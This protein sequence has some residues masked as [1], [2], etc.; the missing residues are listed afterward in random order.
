MIRLHCRPMQTLDF[1]FRL[2]LQGLG[3]IALVSIGGFGYGHAEDVGT[4]TP[5]ADLSA[6]E[7]V[8]E[9]RLLVAIGRF[10][11]VLTTL[12][13]HRKAGASN[14]DLLFLLGLAA[15]GKAQQ[16]GAPEADRDPLLEEAIAAFRGILADRPGFV[17]ARIELA[18]SYFL[19]ENDLLARKHFE[20]ALAG[21]VPS[22]VAENIRLYLAKI[23]ARKHQGGHR[24]RAPALAHLRRDSPLR[25]LVT[26]LQTC[27]SVTLRL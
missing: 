19:K 27:L 26:Q 4:E 21:E 11:E 3:L 1:R 14:P 18:T 5:P 10:D 20:L 15:A 8:D 12:R 22:W 16:A 13:V 9:A 24:G 25:P 6:A 17:R 2:M 23:A 7:A